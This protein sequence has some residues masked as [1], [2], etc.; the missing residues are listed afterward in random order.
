V[1][2]IVDRSA[3]RVSRLDQLVL[4]DFSDMAKLKGIQS[5]P[6]MTIDGMR[7][8][9]QFGRFVF[10]RSNHMSQKTVAAVDLALKRLREHRDS[11]WG[12]IFLQKRGWR[13]YQSV[14]RWEGTAV[15]EAGYA[16]SKQGCGGGIH[17]CGAG[18]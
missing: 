13:T 16:S 14:Y 17:L 15:L 6:A 10:N 12:S 1:A 3:V 9:A 7:R 4:R 2:E 18:V 5:I 11:A 8:V